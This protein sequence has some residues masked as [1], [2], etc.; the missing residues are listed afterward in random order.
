MGEKG[1]EANRGAKT[2]Y[3]M[4]TIHA[5]RD[6][7]LDNL[8]VALQNEIL[9]D[10]KLGHLKERKLVNMYG[11]VMEFWTPDEITY[12]Y[13]QKKNY[14]FHIIVEIDKELDKREW[15]Q[16]YRR[17]FGD[18]ANQPQDHCIDSVVQM[19][20][21]ERKKQAMAYMTAYISKRDYIRAA[22]WSANWPFKEMMEQHEKNPFELQVN[23]GKEKPEGFSL[24]TAL[25]SNNKGLYSL[26]LIT[27][28]ISESDCKIDFRRKRIISESPRGDISW[29]WV[30]FIK[31]F[32][33][34][35][36]ENQCYIPFNKTILSVL[37]HDY[38][39][40][41]KLRY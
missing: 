39:F 31:A 30:G 4:M 33:T 40:P 36:L 26:R 17:Y 22:A 28:I 27:E 3:C 23:Y 8:Q 29:T 19:A 18:M 1:W 9:I 13:L 25:H 2:D 35:N 24:E 16:W 11:F 6:F 38:N 10:Q 21:K 14:H 41:D 7:E 32:I 20:K 37:K 15:F 5:N 34:D 12:K